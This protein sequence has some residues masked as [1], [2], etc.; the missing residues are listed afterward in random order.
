MDSSLKTDL[1]A[2]TFTSFVIVSVALAAGTVRLSSGGDISYGGNT[3]SDVN[4]SYGALERVAAI[5]D[6]ADD[7]IPAYEIEIN[8]PAA[9]AKALWSVTTDQGVDVYVYMGT[10]NRSTG[11]VVGVELLFFGEY[12]YPR[13]TVSENGDRATLVCT[14]QLARLLEP[15]HERK[16][17]D[18]MH[19]ACFSGELGLSFTTR[20]TRKIYWRAT[21]PAATGVKPKRIFGKVVG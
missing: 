16:L 19:Q 8:L 13:F 5:S 2:S 15:N 17:S 14:S 1:Q 11:A 10:I 6:G 9:G 21:D 7:Q 4:A 12:N 20:L 3:Y 18:A